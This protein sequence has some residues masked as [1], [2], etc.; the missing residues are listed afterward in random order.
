[1]FRGVMLKSD[2]L[3]QAIQSILG[4]ATP[5]VPTYVTV[6]TQARI[7]DPLSG[8]YKRTI[9]IT[10][11]AGV[12][13]STLEVEYVPITEHRWIPHYLELSQSSS[14]PSPLQCLLATTALPFGVVPSITIDGRR[15][16]DGGVIDNIPIAPLLKHDLDEIFVVLL[17][18]NGDDAEFQ[19]GLRDAISRYRRDEVLHSISTPPPVKATMDSLSSVLAAHPALRAFGEIAPLTSFR[20]NLPRVRVF[21][22]KQPRGGFADGLLRFEAKFCQQLISD[23][24]HETRVALA[25]QPA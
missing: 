7:Y 18:A 19:N 1:M 2:A 14:S 12:D 20:P 4:D 6:A 13:F 5:D 10:G 9:P 21:R 17:D 22:P 15:Y 23:G 11:P 25:K 24:L 16:V 3:G 8:G